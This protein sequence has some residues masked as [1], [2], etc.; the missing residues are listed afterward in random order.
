MINKS[1]GMNS[2]D[3]YAAFKMLKMYCSSEQCLSTSQS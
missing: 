1:V 3:F 2:K